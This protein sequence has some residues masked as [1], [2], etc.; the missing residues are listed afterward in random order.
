MS[1]SRLVL[2]A[3]DARLATALQSQLRRELSQLVIPCCFATL[4]QQF[5]R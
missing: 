5:G 1:V 3:D 2:V 4:R